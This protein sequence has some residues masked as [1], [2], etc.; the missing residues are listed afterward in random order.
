MAKILAWAL[1]LFT[2]GCFI[3]TLAHQ[4]SALT[5]EEVYAQCGA[6][7]PDMVRFQ[8]ACAAADAA[9]AAD[10]ANSSSPDDVED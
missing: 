2:S 3:A 8:Q 6:P 4:Q 1:F 9:D 10:L 5:Y 7:L